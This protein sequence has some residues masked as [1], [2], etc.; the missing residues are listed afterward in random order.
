MPR[1]RRCTS[2][3]GKDAL[4]EAAPAITGRHVGQGL[5]LRVA[6]RHGALPGVG[7]CLPGLR[8]RQPRVGARAVVDARVRARGLR[9]RSTRTPRRA[10]RRGPSLAA[11]W[12]A[13]GSASLG[14]E[15][16]SCH[17]SCRGGLGVKR[18]YRVRL[19]PQHLASSTG[20]TALSVRSVGRVVSLDERAK[21][22]AWVHVEDDQQPLRC[23][24]AFGLKAHPSGEEKRQP[25]I[26]ATARPDRPTARHGRG[27][28]STTA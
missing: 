4:G 14:T 11:G 2:P 21:S 15:C 12:T 16:A 8:A 13:R 7:A 10:A 3:P 28:A 20:S 25:R 22:P 17:L 1:R 26:R 27:H 18:A 23:S 6:L 24:P 5:G 19:P 9:F